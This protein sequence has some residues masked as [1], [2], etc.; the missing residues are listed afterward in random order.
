M[1][2]KVS[3]YWSVFFILHMS[4]FMSLAF[5]VELGPVQTLTQ[6]GRFIQIK[7][8]SDGDIHL[9]YFRDYNIYYLRQVNDVWQ[10][11]RLVPGSDATTVN[12]SEYPGFDIDSNQNAYFVWGWQIGQHTEIWYNK[13]VAASNSFTSSS[14]ELVIKD[15]YGDADVRRPTM[16]VCPNGRVFVA[17]EADFS[18]EW[19]WRESSGGWKNPTTTIQPYSYPQEPVFPCMACGTNNRPICIFSHFNQTYLDL[20]VSQFN[21]ETTSWSTPK[22]AT[23][24]WLDGITHSTHVAVD[25]SSIPHITWTEWRNG[26]EFDRIGYNSRSG[27][28][29]NDAWNVYKYLYVETNMCTM[30]PVPASRVAVNS[31]GDI[32]VIFGRYK[33]GVSDVRYIFKAAGET[34]PVYTPSNPPPKINTTARQG[35]AGIC[36]DPT[37][38]DMIVAWE[39]NPQFSNIGPIH[40]RRIISMPAVLPAPVLDAANHYNGKIYLNWSPPRDPNGILDYYQLYRQVDGGLWEKI[41]ETSQEY[42]IDPDCWVGSEFTYMVRIIDTYDR[43]SP[44]SNSLSVV[45]Q[46]VPALSLI[47]SLILLG[48]VSLL[49]I[50]ALKSRKKPEAMIQ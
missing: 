25:S 23:L 24:T 49:L 18:I 12:S 5:S 13:F 11:E 9:C 6:H 39:E 45:I 17:T 46:A 38:N 19:D 47:A 37:S 34:W 29:P 36:V 48:F 27:P 32:C 4:I 8:D 28:N 43:S 50:A 22:S 20:G 26:V 7:C 14:G 42:Y 10:T 15:N 40:Y 3:V 41:D 44:F 30:E 21:S 2:T 35:W 31:N 1:K 16:T 33:S